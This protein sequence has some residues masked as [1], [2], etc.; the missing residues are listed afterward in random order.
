MHASDVGALIS[1]A[2][3]GSYA[4]NASWGGLSA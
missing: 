3:C 1:V 2:R 4:A